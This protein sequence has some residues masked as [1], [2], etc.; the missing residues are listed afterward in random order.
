MQ[1]R[2][3]RRREHS[4]LVGRRTGRKGSRGLGDHIVADNPFPAIHGRVCYH[5]RETVC[6]RGTLDEAVN[7]HAVERYLG[8]RALSQGWPLPDPAESSGCRV[9][10]IGAGPSGLSAAYHLRRLG[11]AVSVFEAGPIAG[12]MMALG[13]PRYRLPREILAAEIARIEAMGVEIRLN[14]KVTDLLAHRSAGH[15][16]AIFVAIGAHRQRALNPDHPLIR[17]TAQNPDVFFQAR[18]AVNPFYDKLPSIAAQVFAE[19]AIRT[20]RCYQNFD[21]YGSPDAEQVLVLM[22]S[23]CETVRETIDFL[24]AQGQDLGLLQVR[25]YRPFACAEFGAALP[26]SCRRIAVLDRTME[27]GSAGEPLFQDVL[28][29][30]ADCDRLEI[31]AS[32]G[33]YGLSS[34]EFAPAMV[35]AIDDGLASE[36]PRRSFTVGIHDDVTNSSLEWDSSFSTEAS[37]VYRAVFLGLGADGTVSANK[38]S[39]KIIADAT[40]NYC[41]AFREAEA[42]PGTSLI[43]ACSHCIAHSI[44]MDKGLLS[45][46]CATRL[47]SSSLV[48]AMR[49]SAPFAACSVAK[50]RR[51]RVS[52]SAQTMSR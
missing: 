50:R 17:G 44:S 11:H 40:E 42:Y 22:G 37:D 48:M 45:P 46:S 26:E 13:I 10:V 8:D 16:Q 5:P 4:G 43:L 28:T 47:L 19:F 49:A 9:L 29:A 20:G 27:P 6:C 41:Q 12:G 51:T 36:E 18:E 25:L 1:L 31:R 14:H 38:N 32:R 24:N 23:G 33:R 52:S 3:S 35:K 15:F 7:I 39:I 30:L 34:K 21:Y 2:L